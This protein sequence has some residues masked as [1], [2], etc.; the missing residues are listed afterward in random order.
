MLRTSTFC[1]RGLGFLAGITATVYH[2]YATN[3]VPTAACRVFYF[4]ISLYRDSR[5]TT[6]DYQANWRATIGGRQTLLLAQAQDNR[7]SVPKTSRHGCLPYRSSVIRFLL[8][9]LPLLHLLC[10]SA[11]L[12]SSNAAGGFL[13]SCLPVLT[14][15]ANHLFKAIKRHG[16]S[17][18][19]SS[20]ILRCKH[21]KGRYISSDWTEVLNVK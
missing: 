6:A 3:A 11:V 10:F 9:P 7:S 4:V 18:S 19:N 17:L 16:L 21:R 1:L 15:I 14:V 20:T 12:A 8:S 13:T 5:L 2:E